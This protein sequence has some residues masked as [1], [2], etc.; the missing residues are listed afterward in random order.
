MRR[1]WRGDPKL[2][3]VWYTQPTSQFRSY[4]PRCK[5]KTAVAAA[6]TVVARP[7]PLAISS[8]AGMFIVQVW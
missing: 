6:A 3:A 2:T 7:A 5:A 8:V 4:R 1:W